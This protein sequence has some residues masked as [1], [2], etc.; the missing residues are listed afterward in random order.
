M[1]SDLSF[2]EYVCDQMQ[3][4]GTVRFR[5][6]FGEFAIYCDEKVVALVCDDQLFVRPTQ[7]GRS[8]LGNPVEAS[9][10]IGA[11][12]HLLIDSLGD[13]DWLSQLIRLTARDLP[14][15]KPKR[16]KSR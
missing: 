7:A 4:A 14:E 15:P 16:R 8:F 11:Q 3:L 2:V 10:Y 5:K 6:M 13:R 12:P 1:S 9:P